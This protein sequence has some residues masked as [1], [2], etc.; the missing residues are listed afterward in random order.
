MRVADGASNHEH[1]HH[2]RT[3]HFCYCDGQL[4]IT[5]I[6]WVSHRGAAPHKT[7]PLSVRTPTTR[8]ATSPRGHEMQFAVTQQRVLVDSEIRGVV[9]IPLISSGALFSR[10][11]IRVDAPSDERRVSESG[12]VRCDVHP[13]V[14]GY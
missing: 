3:T 1:G 7:A 5:C 9:A 11:N 10:H 12:S 8:G 13:N 14:L 4:Q 6:S 2:E